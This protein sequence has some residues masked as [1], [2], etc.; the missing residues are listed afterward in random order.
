VLDRKWW[1]LKY[2]LRRG[3]R[4]VARWLNL[5][6]RDIPSHTVISTSPIGLRFAIGPDD[7]FSTSMFSVPTSIL[8][9]SSCKPFFNQASRCSMSG[10]ISAGS[11]FIH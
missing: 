4:R 7:V 8:K 2:P 1:L 3:R 6:H 11:A 10:R 5:S 9:P